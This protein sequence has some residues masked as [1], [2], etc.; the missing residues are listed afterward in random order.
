MIKSAKIR[1]LKIANNSGVLLSYT[2]HCLAPLIKDDSIFV[3]LL[4]KAKTGTALNL[5]HPKSFNEKLQWLKL[6]NKR[7]EYTIMVDKVKVKDYVASV[8]GKD[9]VI[10]TLGVWD[11]PEKINFNKLPDKF[12]IKCNHNSGTGMYICTDKKQMDVK[13]VK[14]GLKKGL[15]ENYFIYNRE[16]PYK[17]VPRRI[18]AEQFLE[19]D[20]E[21]K[22]LMD[23]KLFCFDGEV[24]IIEVDYNRFI[25]HNRNL[26]TPEWKRMEVEIEFPSEPGKEFQRPNGLEMAIEAA[27]KLSKGIPHVR[28]DFYIVNGHVYFGE[29]TF[30][31]GSGMEKITPASFNEE[32]GSWIHVI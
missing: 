22:D 8:I 31:H 2:L 27:Q 25:H 24:K 30:F 32:M 26:Y 20:K 15:K 7:P 18:I 4:W 5:N 21:L 29:M 17:D 23:Y 11:D 28:V 3:R 14:E 1:I 6:Y 9:F 10:P 16:Y 12:V 13:K 19:P